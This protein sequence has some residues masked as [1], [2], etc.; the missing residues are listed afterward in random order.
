MTMDSETPAI[1]PAAKAATNSQSA[2]QI[3][4]A[5]CGWA[6]D[7]LVETWVLGRRLLLCANPWLCHLNQMTLREHHRLS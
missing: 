1:A 7:G 6:A 3:G 2:P 5:D 4:C